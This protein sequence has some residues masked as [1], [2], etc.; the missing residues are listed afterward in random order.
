MPIEMFQVRFSKGYKYYGKCFSKNYKDSENN[1]RL[2]WMKNLPVGTLNGKFFY[3]STSTKLDNYR[4]FIGVL[5]FT[6]F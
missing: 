6:D 1:Y 2:S 3:F 5:F 4:E